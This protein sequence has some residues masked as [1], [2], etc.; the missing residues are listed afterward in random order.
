[1][2]EL[3]KSV[4]LSRDL[5]YCKQRV[6]EK[7]PEPDRSFVLTALEACE[8]ELSTMQKLERDSTGLIDQIRKLHEFIDL[9]E[10]QLALLQK[11]LEI[12]EG[13]HHE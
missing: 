11:T 2:I 13:K 1:M 12:L 8:A 9:M 6:A 3:P 7:V 5:M 10:R 4:Q